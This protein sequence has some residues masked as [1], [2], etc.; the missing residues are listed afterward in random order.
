MLWCIVTIISLKL[1]AFLPYF[2]TV[3]LSLTLTHS[4][5][6][7]FEGNMIENCCRASE[8]LA[9]ALE[10]SLGYFFKNHFCLSS[11]SWI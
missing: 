11:S 2:W 3:P 9:A 6:L 8:G 5:S 1:H 7:S 4:L 10:V